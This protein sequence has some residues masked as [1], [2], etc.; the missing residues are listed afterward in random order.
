MQAGKLYNSALGHGIA[1]EWSNYILLIDLI[2]Q[3]DK[4]ALAVNYKNNDF[5]I[6]DVK[7]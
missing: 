4:L 6:E 3:I 2:C 7:W 5:S 1:S